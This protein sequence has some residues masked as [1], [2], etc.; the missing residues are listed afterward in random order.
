ML[1]STLSHLLST[2]VLNLGVPDHN[3]L[4]RYVDHFAIS[5]DGNW[6]SMRRCSAK[7]S[8]TAF[9][10]ASSARYARGICRSFLF[11][12][13]SSP[14]SYYKTKCLWINNFKSTEFLKSNHFGIMSC[15][16]A[17]LT[18]SLILIPVSQ[19]SKVAGEDIVDKIINK[20]KEIIRK[21]LFNVCTLRNIGSVPI[22]FVNH[23]LK[24]LK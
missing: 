24:Q 2:C 18:T 3:L 1:Q 20:T 19:M 5:P 9:L 14:L 7:A 11:F 4:G 6:Y 16:L 22:L 12:L 23:S 13:I 10:K 15:C 8:A 21:K 17:K